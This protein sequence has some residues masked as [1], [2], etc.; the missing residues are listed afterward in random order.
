M[1]G[2]AGYVGTAP[3]ELLL[4]M[5]RRL[6]HRGPDGTG[7]HETPGAGLGATRLAIIDL[8]GGQQPMASEDGAVSIVF[9]GE[10]Y[11]HRELRP[12][13][14]AE[15]HRFRTR[16]DT[17]AVLHA[18]AQLGDAC[19][20]E[21]RGMFAFAIW[22]G[23]R[24]RLLL[25]RDRLGKKPLYYWQRNGLFLFASE[26]KALL[27][28]AAVG[29]ELDWDSFHHYLAFGYTPASRSIFA[30]IAKLPPGHTAVLED[31]ALRLRRYWALPPP[32]AAPP[33]TSPGEA[34]ARVRE[35]VR[36]AVRLRLESDVPLGVFLSG[37]I[38]SSIV[39]ACMREITGQRIRTFAVG[40][41]RGAP[42]YDELPFARRV[43][44][45][46][47]TD[48]MEEILEPRV[49]D[50]LPAIAQHLD[51]PFADSS[52]VPTFVVAQ[53]AARHLKVALTGIGGDE[54]FGGYPRYLGVRLSEIYARVPRPLRRPAGAL[55]RRVARPSETSR[56]W[57]DWADRFVTGADRPLPARYI[58]WMR[59]F[60]EPQ[61][62]ALVTPA[63]G[64]RWR[65]E[66]ESAHRA[67]YA[68][69]RP[70]D[71]V[72]GAMRIDLETYLPDDLLM[73]ADRMG[74]AHSLELRAPFCDHRLVELSL[75]LP[76]ALKLP[77][78]RLKGL[79][80]TA[81]AGVLPAEVLA[82]RKQGFMIPLARWL[83]TELRP[84]MEDLLAPEQVR[85]RGLF[86][87]D[88]V[89]RLKHEHLTGRGAHG[90]RLWALMM[91]EL[92]I[93]E[94]L[95]GAGPWGLR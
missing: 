61:L 34:A 44:Q 85:R 82:R 86:A 69:R 70:H 68:G 59:V 35:A 38:D 12:R 77:G 55:L 47:E 37:G 21:L 25:A 63:L 52:A 31:G 1:C 14:E 92:W 2:I 56:N 27:C 60:S 91:A 17:E 78:L 19:V 64:G 26:L 79:L 3:P 45:R 93:R 66:I 41:G 51:E 71:P 81:F 28:H 22:D 39:V 46:F 20:A 36:D 65:T 8:A 53:A 58:G 50:L 57:Q 95:D 32:G 76:S 88:A 89:E 84:V 10:V 6:K 67:A 75:G 30:E 33:P 18:Y 49:E 23:R 87:P 43:A 72:D 54:T 80:K 73:M 48:H 16:S 11:N 90:D 62:A 15:G 24:R 40:F 5:L 29:R 83:R 4:A 94:Y 13:L 9:N 42:S 74:M 7:C